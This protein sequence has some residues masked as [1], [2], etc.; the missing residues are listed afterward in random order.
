MQ[1]RAVTLAA[2]LT[3]AI[4]TTAVVIAD[5]SEEP[6]VAQDVDL[7]PEKLALL[8]DGGAGYLVRVTTQDGGSAVRSTTAR[9]VRRLA[10]AG[11]NACRRV[12]S[13]GGLVDPG[14]LNRFQA[15][16]SVGTRCQS[17]ACSVYAGDDADGEE[18]ERVNRVR[19]GG[20]E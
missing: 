7:E 1:S 20:R 17:V 11:V 2:M 6:R 12:Q 10:D 13:D 5:G 16:A 8:R 18:T 19:D 4:V 14:T 9:C 15:D 3:G